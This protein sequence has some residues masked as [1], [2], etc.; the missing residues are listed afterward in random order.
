MKK[1]V[2]SSTGTPYP[3][4]KDVK[5]GFEASKRF[6]ARVNEAQRHADNIATVKAL[7]KRV[8]DWKG[9]HIANFGALKLDD[10][11][12][13]NKSEVDRDYHV[14]LFE[15]I[16]L[17]C[18]EPPV[19]GSNNGSLK[20]V[21]KSDSLLKKGGSFSSPPVP[22]SAQAKK[23]AGP[24]ML[25][26]RIFLSNVTLAKS[27]MIDGKFQST[28]CCFSGAN[29]LCQYSGVNGLEVWWRGDDEL[30]Y[31]TLKCRTEEQMKM[32]EKELN[33]LI[34]EAHR[35]SHA[36][37]RARSPTFSPSA[38]HPS[39]VAAAVSTMNSHQS[40]ISAASSQASLGWGK[41]LRQYD[42]Q[43]PLPAQGPHHRA[44]YD[45]DA[46]V[47]DDYD[48]SVADDRMSVYMRRP[49]STP[50]RSHTSSSSYGGHSNGGRPLT[51]GYPGHHYQRSGSSF[52]HQPPMPSQ[53]PQ[54]QPV[55]PVLRSQ[56][57]S[58]KLGSEYAE[59]DES[60]PRAATT[61]QHVSER[62]TPSPFGNPR[63]RSVSTPIASQQAQQH[64]TVPIDQ[65]Q[66]WSA[67]T[68][69]SSL[70]SDSVG[71]KRGSGSSG[72]SDPSSGYSTNDQSGESPIT[73]YG[74]SGSN[75]STSMLM[76]SKQTEVYRL[77]QMSSPAP[78]VSATSANATNV[79]EEKVKIK[80]H[81][82]Q[83]IFVIMV[84]KSIH[85]QDLVLRVAQKV[86]LCGG[87][88]DTSPLRIKYMDEEN[89]MVTLGS[90]EDIQMAFDTNLPQI[91][92]FVA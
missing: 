30:E 65:S 15:K 57:S 21:K 72:L 29:L 11:F 58:L 85:Y 8:M 92:F 12:S 13:V 63:L 73:P 42:N 56:F 86:R 1:N 46:S 52:R 18:K 28:F 54:Q 14:F 41:G 74:S 4:V 84:A 82:R 10:M 55:R 31:F 91:S 59:D 37:E 38:A 5:E 51:D 32:W 76:K 71:T 61:G 87:E 81:Y 67:T 70:M 9:H 7:E 53:Q 36:P 66:A 19:P 22:L 23:S 43:V 26:G 77:R 75:I 80:V 90:D 78:N 20:K 40:S 64:P 79:N 6:T 60:R 3:Y 39:M 83:D 62:A 68:S 25:K 17:C 34:G 33:T 16:I 45:D 88:R 47:E 24:L 48:D 35:R 69:E 89:D 50:A 44:Y 49:G 2:E 27:V